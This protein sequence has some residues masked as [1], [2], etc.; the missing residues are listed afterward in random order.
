MVSS[1]TLNRLAGLT[2]QVQTELQAL[3]TQ[4]GIG[5]E[6][7]TLEEGAMS[8][9]QEQDDVV[10]TEPIVAQRD[11]KLEIVSAE[12][13]EWTV[14][15]AGEGGAPGH[16][17]EAFKAMKLTLQITDPTVQT[18]HEGA[19]PRLTLEH[20][21][22][23]DRYPYLDKKSGG[24]RWLGRANLYELE[25]AFGFDPVFTNGEGQPV[26]PY[27]TRNGRKMAPRGEGIK[28]SLNP[29]FTQAYFTP[30]GNPSLEWSGRTVYADVAIEKDERYGDRNRIQRFKRPPVAV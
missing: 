26:E 2:P 22:N 16:E 28:R 7:L 12:R 23:L 19:R 17:G 30:D 10:V 3:M 9:Q 27:I 18:E 20:Q 1:T 8:W 29:A 14:K 4:F 5:E 21:M 15:A 13:A 6:Q 11:V 25:E 24:V